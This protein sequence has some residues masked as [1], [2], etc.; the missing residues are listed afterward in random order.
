[1]QV[2][3]SHVCY[4]DSNRP[5]SAE[6]KKELKMSNKRTG[7]AAADAG[8]RKS[9]YRIWSMFDWRVKKPLVNRAKAAF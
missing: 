5:K 8:R 7:A 2:N 3:T 9:E 1:V 4:L 6:R